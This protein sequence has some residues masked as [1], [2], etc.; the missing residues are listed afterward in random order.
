MTNFNFLSL[1]LAERGI[2]KLQSDYDHW[3]YTLDPAIDFVRQVLQLAASILEYDPTQLP[4]QILA[5]ITTNE[6]L[7]SLIHEVSTYKQTLWLRPLCP[8][9]VQPGGVAVRTIPLSGEGLP[10][11][12]ALTPDDKQ[13][14]V[15]VGGTLYCFDLKSGTILFSCAGDA[16]DITDLTITQDGQYAVAASRNG[17]L[18]IW[19][20][21]IR[22]QLSVLS[23]HESAVLAVQPMAGSNVITASTDGKLKI[24]DIS[25]GQ[26]ICRLEG[27]TESV[28][29]VA[30]LDEGKKAISGG[31]SSIS[32]FSEYHHLTIWDLH[33]GKELESFGDHEWPVDSLAVVDKWV[34]S[35]A[36]EI[37]KVWDIN[38]HEQI[39]LLQAHDSHI[40]KVHRVGVR[41]VIS[42]SSDGN[43]KLWD[44]QTGEN[45]LL[46]RGHYAL[47]SD[48]AVTRDG[49]I[50]ASI[51]WDQTL[52]LWDLRRREADSNCGHENA[53]EKII[54]SPC[55]KWIL[56]ASK[57]QSIKIWDSTTY[58]VH[59]TLKG[60]KHWVS[61]IAISPD[62]CRIVS[63][64]WDT[65]IKIWSFDTGLEEFSLATGDDPV[66][67]IVLHPDGSLLIGGTIKGDLMIWDLEKRMVKRA[68]RA[69]DQSIEAL[70]LTPNGQS[71]LSVSNDQ[72]L[73][74]WD[75]DTGGLIFSLEGYEN[76]ASPAQ[77]GSD[78]ERLFIRQMS[79][80][81]MTDIVVTHDGQHA[82]TGAL[83]GYISIWDI[84]GRHLESN[85]KNSTSGI[86]AVCISADGK[87]IAAATGLPHYQSD[88]SVRLWATDTQH[89]LAY[90]VG[91]APMSACTF[92][93]N[94]EMLIV[95]DT[96]GR[97]LFLDIC[98]EG[99]YFP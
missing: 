63:A 75:I 76:T 94:S 13:V 98:K 78:E 95:G 71:F 17:T 97:V 64:S 74:K 24:W 81:G 26:E 12:V 99:R 8:S 25:L 77:A 30:V 88:N 9:L 89:M 3:N 43:L 35:A 47:V 72:K 92:T 57:D 2:E 11:A 55:G 37:L 70:G 39:Y 79:N 41:S 58:C 67:A 56:T 69:H 66:S 91:D 86:S 31:D 51:G 46:L 23:A 19:H 96:L 59:R 29:C 61:D 22:E 48:V 18:T 84:K 7:K 49:Q 60:H 90:F 34:V 83:N 6:A 80:E 65:T 4:E 20:L 52:H 73:K 53:V 40:H 44:L 16:G 5:R 38:T 87:Y 82:I 50:A 15:T 36:N 93:P 62:G 32:G 33:S 10:S 21:G 45:T 28:H 68:F 1:K 85:F 54:V 27:H 42:A 14:M